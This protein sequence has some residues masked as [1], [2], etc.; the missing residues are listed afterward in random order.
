MEV[1]IMK[2][3][4]KVSFGFMMG[5][6]AACILGQYI[7]KRINKKDEANKNESSDLNEN[8]EES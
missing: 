7:D 4:F 6:Y 8:E 1:I 5:A 3:A 2:E